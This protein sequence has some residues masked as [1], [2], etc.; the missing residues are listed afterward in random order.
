M[1]ACVRFLTTRSKTTKCFLTQ[2]SE[3][4]TEQRVFCVS[5]YLTLMIICQDFFYFFI[6]YFCLKYDF[7]KYILRFVVQVQF[8]SYKVYVFKT[9]KCFVCKIGL[10]CCELLRPVHLFLFCLFLIYVVFSLYYMRYAYISV[11]MVFNKI[12]MKNKEN[13]NIKHNFTTTDS[14]A[15]PQLL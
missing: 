15:Y 11:I 3:I 13:F 7:L 10:V 6:N 4:R 9:K 1:L 12:Q 14:F 2:N 5:K 8:I